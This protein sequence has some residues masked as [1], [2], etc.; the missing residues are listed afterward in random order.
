M[1]INFHYFAV[2]AIALSVG[3]EESKAQTIAEFSQFIDD[4]D[5]YADMALE[6]VPEDARR[7]AAKKGGWYAFRP[8]TTG[9]NSYYDY[10]RLRNE[11]IQRWLV[12]PFHFIPGSKLSEIPDGH[13]IALRTQK[14]AIGD[15]TLI[16]QLLFAAMNRYLERPE[17][18][19]KDLIRIG[20]L[21]HIFADTHSHDGF[22]GFAGWENHGLIR[23]AHDID[24]GANIDVNIERL[25][26]LKSVGHAN[27]G[28]LPDRSNWFIHF[29]QKKSGGPTDYSHHVFHNNT[30]SFLDASKEITRYLSYCLNKPFNEALWPSIASLLKKGFR[31]N[32]SEPGLLSTHWTG[33]IKDNT[34]IE[35]IEQAKRNTYAGRQIFSYSKKAMMSRL[36]PEHVYAFDSEG[37]SSIIPFSKNPFAVG[38]AERDFF[39]FNLIANEIREY[40]VGK[41]YERLAPKYRGN[42]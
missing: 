4:F 20:M 32:E 30:D 39:D 3:F 40:V 17:D 21:L 26:L 12:A 14:A 8:V 42:D 22:S 13:R 18:D 19:T 29:T 27:V 2:K 35:G 31:T 23:T 34:G 11:D 33:L 7:F 24:N 41:E 36:L 1:D 38:R 37:F 16:D 15:R 10:Y 6:E 25:H 5:L 28:T 9:F